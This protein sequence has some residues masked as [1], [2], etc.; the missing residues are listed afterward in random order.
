[1]GGRGLGGGRGGR[2][3]LG[4]DGAGVIGRRTSKQCGPLFNGNSTEV[5]WSWLTGIQCR[6]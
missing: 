6:T 5:I 4:R 3:K 1:M 2:G